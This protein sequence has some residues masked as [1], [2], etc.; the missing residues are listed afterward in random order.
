MGWKAKEIDIFGNEMKKL[1]PK[2]LK[3]SNFVYFHEMEN[4]SANKNGS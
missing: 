4:S 1:L 2:A 3:T